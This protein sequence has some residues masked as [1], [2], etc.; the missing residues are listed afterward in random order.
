MWFACLSVHDAA[1]WGIPQYASLGLTGEDATDSW[2]SLGVHRR[3]YRLA[4][5][6]T[7]SSGPSLDF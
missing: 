5:S 2:V 4:G 7:C 6:V 3:T 1:D